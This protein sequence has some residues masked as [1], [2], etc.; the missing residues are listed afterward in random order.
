MINRRRIAL[1]AVSI[2]CLFPIAVH[3]GAGGNP[4]A[5]GAGK[6]T[7]YCCTTWEKVTQPSGT[8]EQGK[9]KKTIP[10][11]NGTGCQAIAEDDF[12]MNGCSGTTAKCRGEFFTPRTG[13]VERCL[14]P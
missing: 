14:T 10:F 6:S 1:A 13:K 7:N 2:S 11:L 8:D 12:S 9:E 3:A 4:T 5:P